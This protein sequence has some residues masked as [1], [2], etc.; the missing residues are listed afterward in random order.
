MK[1]N[2]MFAMI[3]AIALTGSVGFTA[4]SSNDDVAE[5]NP[6]YD[7]ATNSVTTKFV[8]NINPAAQ[9]T[10]RQTAATVQ[11]ANNFRGMKDAKLIG[12]ST[13]K[14]STFLAPFL[15]SSKK[16]PTDENSASFDVIHTYDLGTLY[17]SGSVDN[18]PESDNANSSSHRVVELTLPLKTDAMLVYGR[19][20][21][22]TTISGSSTVTDY[23][24]NGSVTYTIS[25]TPEQ[26]SF[27][28]N[29]RMADA[30]A[31]T[32]CC[33]LATAILNH[34]ML[35]GIE[36]H[37]V[38]NPIT[39]KSYDY[40]TDPATVVGSYTQEAALPAL[41][42]RELGIKSDA[43]I[44]LLAPLQENLAN[45]YSVIR[46][47]YKNSE[48]VNSGSAASLCNMMKDVYIIV[49]SVAN[50]IATNDAELNAQL[51]ADE[52]KSRIETFF[53]RDNAA[54][55]FRSVGTSTQGN[56]ILKGLT[57]AGINVT[58]FTSV[59]DNNFP[60]FPKSFNVP[61][62]VAQLDFTDFTG[63]TTISGG[64]KYK[65]AD[66]SASLVNLSA[67]LNPTK[68][69]Y[70]SE[71]LYFDNSL[72]RVTDAEKEPKDFPDGYSNWDTGGTP[73]L[74]SG[75]NVG[76]VTSGTRSV[77]VKN[78]I[79]YGVAMLQSTVVIDGSSFKD[80]HPENE[81]VTFTSAQVGNFILTGVLIGGQYKQVG[82]N[83]L[84]NSV[85]DANKNYVIYDN[86]MASNGST[87]AS[88]ATP[89]YTLVF[90]NY[91]TSA[92]QDPVYVALEFMNGND[93]DIYGKGGIIPKG[94][95]FYLA[96]KLQLNDATGTITW[97]TTY[98]IPPYTDAG[99]SQ[100]IKRIFI[101]DYVTT[102]IFKIGENSLKNAYTTVPDLRA[103]QTSLGLSVDLNWR[104][105]LSFETVLGN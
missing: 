42:W 63:E 30:T 100:E 66:A 32:Q 90:D 69:M 74:W 73:N 23:E 49:S 78:N 35:S 15:G 50:A 55:P 70:P 105:G 5:T 65:T 58:G 10:T 54:F 72:L 28:L 77:A 13:G 11:K 9:G 85:A 8:L 80:N 17:A 26:T 95:T 37:S 96:A 56:S 21:P 84:T 94:G 41:T 62:G 24:A 46:K 101:Q 29:P 89:N 48:A 34:I 57:D 86:K 40:S 52:I 33:D 51:L 88:T 47:T 87:V 20:I 25:S 45:V 44:A 92:D 67:Y 43:D 68:Y 31:Y 60:T 38:E 75:W 71:L 102:A 76:P 1:K 97:P 91:N 93:M 14:A 2:F 6:N 27:T 19:A 36:A 4:C 22:V 82:W 16:D 53:E 99:A 18:E 39:R 83:Y 12:L 98:A 61:E 3:G 79:N 64:F 59:N 103:S 7:P 81:S 104:P